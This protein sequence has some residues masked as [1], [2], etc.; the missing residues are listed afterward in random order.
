V[1][2][3]LSLKK[4]EVLQQAFSDKIIIKGENFVHTLAR[5][6]ETNN[7]DLLQ[8]NLSEAPTKLKHKITLKLEHK[9]LESLFT[10][11]NWNSLLKEDNVLVNGFIKTF[12]KQFAST[13]IKLSDRYVMFK[14]PIDQAKHFLDLAIL[15]TKSHLD[16]VKR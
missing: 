12:F 13:A 11:L 5:D 9:T 4:I 15:H 8:A 10:K 2:K 7:F 14:T 3:G 1:S 6:R 16:K